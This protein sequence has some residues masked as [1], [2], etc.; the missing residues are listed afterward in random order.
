MFIALWWGVLAVIILGINLYFALAPKVAESQG[1]ISAGYYRDLIGDDYES[2]E[3]HFIAAGFKNIELIDLDDSG[4]AF[5]NEGKVESISVGG[6]TDLKAL[7]KI[8]CKK[9]SK[10]IRK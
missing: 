8:L 9:E 4:I 7:R 10:Q 2:V 3:A 1:K 6:D 5:W